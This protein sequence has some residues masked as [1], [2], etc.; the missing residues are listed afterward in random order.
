MTLLEHY[1]NLLI[2]RYRLSNMIYKVVKLI[3]LQTITGNILW[4]TFSGKQKYSLENISLL[5]C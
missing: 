5:V 2:A 1:A 3:Y 4:K